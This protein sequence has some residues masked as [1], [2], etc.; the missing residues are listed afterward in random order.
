MEQLEQLF[1]YFA[2]ILT[3]LI[4]GAVAYLFFKKHTE[5]EEGRRRFLL[6]KEAQG[7]LLPLRL[8]AYER[9][10]LFLERMDL[11]KSVVRIKPRNTSVE[12]YENDLV[13][14]IEQEYEHNLTQQIYVSAE[15]WNIIRTAKNATIQT[16]R[17]TAMNEKTDSADKLRETLLNNAMAGV[18]PSQ[19][20]LAFLKAEISELF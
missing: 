14:G 6:H 16:V 13:N 7:K 20:A 18:S 2:L 5:N 10:T 1:P 17:Q 4:V 19:K 12:N 11:N 8:Q 9:I 3:A 15:A